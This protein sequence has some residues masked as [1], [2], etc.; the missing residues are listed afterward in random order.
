MGEVVIVA[1]AF[2]VTPDEIFPNGCCY[3]PV[4]S[5]TGAGFLETGLGGVIH[6]SLET[7]ILGH[8]KPPSAAR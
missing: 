5:D 8:I 6:C 4:D 2:G 1:V 3:D 7:L